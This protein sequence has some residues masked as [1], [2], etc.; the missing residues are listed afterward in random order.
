MI[1]K[2]LLFVNS[3]HDHVEQEGDQVEEVGD[4][5]DRADREGDWQ[6]HGGGGVVG[7]G[8]GGLHPYSPTDIVDFLYL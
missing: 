5:V 6:H 4:C 2:S 3:L 7:P 1:L 8:K